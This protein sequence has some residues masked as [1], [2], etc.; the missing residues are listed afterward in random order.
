MPKVAQSKVW[1]DWESMDQNPVLQVSG[2]FKNYGQQ[3]ALCGVELSLRRGEW[4]ALLGPNGAGK[5]TLIRA[6]AGRVFLDRG[7][8]RMLGT[9]LEQGKGSGRDNLGVVPQEIAL[10][11]T[12]TARE[13]LNVFGSLHGVHGKTLAERIRWALDWVALT[14]RANDRVGGFSGGMKRRLNIAAAVL[15]RPE[16][17]LL[18]EPTVGVDPQSR[19]RIWDMLRQLQGEGTSLLLTTH[20]LD[21]AQQICDRIVIVDHGKAIAEGTLESLI[22]QTVGRERMVEIQLEHKLDAHAWQAAVIDPDD[23]TLLRQ[24]MADLAAELPS[25]LA[26]IQSAGGSVRDVHIR[27]PNLQTVFIHLTGR[28]LRE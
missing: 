16:V 7:E 26:E 3:P 9:E 28:A 18:D 15:H 25:L 24:P 14:E 22:E 23:A 27:V 21:E 11:P 1:A 12:L 8:I 10:Y 19:E 4:L 5:T 13:N 6:I 20:Q 17:L 2:A